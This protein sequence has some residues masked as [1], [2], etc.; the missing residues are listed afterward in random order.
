MVFFKE[1]DN[2]VYPTSIVKHILLVINLRDN[3]IPIL[4]SSSFFL[5]DIVN[6]KLKN[7]TLIVHLTGIL[8]QNWYPWFYGIFVNVS[9]H[10]K[11][12]A[13][14]IEFNTELS[15]NIILWEIVGDWQVLT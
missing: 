4:N 8:Q 10:L 12:V 7:K 6:S 11:I 2:R 5:I 1:F 3:V 13:K 9:L 14:C 15:G